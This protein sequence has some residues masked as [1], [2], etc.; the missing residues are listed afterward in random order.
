MAPC[1]PDAPEDCHRTLFTAAAAKTA[2]PEAEVV[3][4]RTQPAPATEPASRR[5][6]LPQDLPG[7]LKHLNDSELD[8]LHKA[9]LDELKR[10]DRLPSTVMKESTP[11]HLTPGRRQTP[12]DHEVGSLTKGQ[13]N[14]VRAAF[15]AGV[16]PA[17]IARQ[18][19]IS[20]SDIR[21]ALAAELR[22]RKPVR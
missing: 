20:Q 19:G 11:A 14:A 16:K 15:K 6:L 12:S 21:K 3:T 18:F 13:L 7:A 1:Q 5:H 4:P 22:D 2:L 10:R 9:T 17:A 8:A